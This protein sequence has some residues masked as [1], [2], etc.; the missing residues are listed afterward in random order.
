MNV[1]MNI[2]SVEKILDK[3]LA[4]FQR[5]LPL[6]HQYIIGHQKRLEEKNWNIQD[7]S[8]QLVGII[9]NGTVTMRM[10]KYRNKCSINVTWYH[11]IVEK[12][13]KNIY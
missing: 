10:S 13:N 6:H 2:F 9:Q 7:H 4:D 11:C 12:E 3:K 8:A 5:P 1:M